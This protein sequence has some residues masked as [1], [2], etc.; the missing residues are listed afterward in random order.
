MQII[1][2]KSFPLV[3]IEILNPT[4]VC[5]L[6]VHLKARGTSCCAQHLNLWLP[7][8]LDLL[9]DYIQQHSIL[10]GNWVILSTLITVPLKVCRNCPIQENF[11]NRKLGG[12]SCILRGVRLQVTLRF[13]GYSLF[14]WNISDYFWNDVRSQFWSKTFIYI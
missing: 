11:L 13:I 12:K 6:G 8:Q 10:F 2:S 4:E 7:Y 14:C 5:F 9:T 1:E 3:R